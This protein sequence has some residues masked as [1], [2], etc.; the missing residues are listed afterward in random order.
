MIASKLICRFAYPGIRFVGP[1]PALIAA[2]ALLALADGPLSADQPHWGTAWTRNMVSAEKNLPEGFQA[3]KRDPETG[4]IE[5]PADSG[6]RW[7]ARVGG[8]SYGTPIVAGGRVLVGTNNEQPRDPKYEGDR[9]VLMCFDEKTGQYLWQLNLPKF[10]KVKWAD[11]HY[12]G[13]SSPPVVEGR[14]VYLVSNRAEVMCLDLD[15]LANGNDGPFTDEAK[16]FAGEGKPPVELGPNDADILWL[17]DMPARLSVEPHN[18]A[19]CAILIDGNL[20]YIC[21]SHGVEWTHK[22]VVTPT[23]PTLIVLDKRNGRLLARDDFGIGPDIV[24]GQWSSPTMGTV[25]G[26]KQLCLG[27]GNGRVYAFAPLDPA[28]VP[29]EAPPSAE[30]SM[31]SGEIPRLTNLW[32]FNGQPLAQTQDH[33]PMDHQHDTTSYIVTAVP[34]YHNNRVYV[35]ITQ[36]VFH[37]LKLGWLVCLDAAGRGD[38]TRTGLKWSYDAVAGSVATVAIADG[39][40]YAAGFDGKL[41]C[42]DAETGQVHWVHH[43]GKPI[44]ASPLV[45][46]GKVYLGTGSQ[47]FWILRH[48][49]QLEVVNRIRMPSGVYCTA[50]A[51]NGTLFIA[52]QKNLYAVG[53]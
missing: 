1:L 7:T 22:Y 25:D 50:T 46:D 9:G 40:L 48:G 15:G 29:E 11:W 19:N 6:V 8:Q 43:C 21:T 49:K 2:A 31:P 47:T 39:L 17:F 24:H 4:E 38:I 41:H 23:A 27:A 51:A 26:K 34:V 16:L 35:P 33:V 10:T 14:K 30:G 42:L 36:E 5:L 18:A 53:K 37:N 3:G 12:V 45:A 32:Q 44:W 52:T 13:I 20:M 28:L